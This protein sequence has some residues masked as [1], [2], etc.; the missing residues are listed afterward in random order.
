M[1]GKTFR[2]LV[3][4]IVYAETED[5]EP[6]VGDLDNFKDIIRELKVLARSSP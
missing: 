2:Q 6:K 4:G 5:G 3:K 1:E